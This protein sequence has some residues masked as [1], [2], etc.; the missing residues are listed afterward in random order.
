MSER[1]I[2]IF[3]FQSGGWNRHNAIDPTILAINAIKQTLK[4][5]IHIPIV[6]SIISKTFHPVILVF[7]LKNGLFEI[8]LPLLRLYVLLQA[9][10][11]FIR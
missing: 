1:R 11:D 6:I 3:F 5:I 10:Q 9:G 4:A 8:A 7:Q 2:R